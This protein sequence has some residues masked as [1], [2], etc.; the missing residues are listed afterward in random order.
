M[1]KTISKLNVMYTLVN[2][3]YCIHIGV[4]ILSGYVS[5]RFGGTN[6][7]KYLIYNSIILR[8]ALAFCIG[9]Y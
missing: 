3:L 8:L 7:L 4:K 6:N 9:G 2:K 1:K 5:G